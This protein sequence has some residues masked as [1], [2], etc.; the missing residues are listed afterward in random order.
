[1]Q[2]FGQVAMGPVT[3]SVELHE[4]QPQS[5]IHHIKNNSSFE[6]TKDNDAQIDNQYESEDEYDTL[7]DDNA[8]YI[9]QIFEDAKLYESI[10][11]KLLIYW[12]SLWIILGMHLAVGTNTESIIALIIHF[13]VIIVHIIF[14]IIAFYR[15]GQKNKDADGAIWTFNE[16]LNELLG[17]EWR[18]PENIYNLDQISGHFVGLEFFAVAISMHSAMIMNRIWAIRW[19][20]GGGVLSWERSGMILYGIGSMFFVSI[21]SLFSIVVAK[22]Y[23]L[24]DDIVLKMFDYKDNKIL[25]IKNTTIGQ[26]LN[27]AIYKKTLQKWQESLYLSNRK[28][29]HFRIFYSYIGNIASTYPYLHTHCHNTI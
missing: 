17:M 24:D 12:F 18:D 10:N 26:K 8:M 5:N 21:G 4:Q 22:F 25:T 29:T 3:Q 13:M 23:V 15:K 20:I 7:Y 1:M 28:G 27:D 19:N 11:W 9:K 6:D 2:Q 16:C 14:I